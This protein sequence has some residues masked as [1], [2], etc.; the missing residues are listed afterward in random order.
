MADGTA[1]DEGYSNIWIAKFFLVY[2]QRK[3][4]VPNIKNNV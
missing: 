3:G 4:R 1:K 2:N